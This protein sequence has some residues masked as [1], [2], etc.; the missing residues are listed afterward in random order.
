M[1]GVVAYE[2]NIRSFPLDACA[3]LQV[4]ISYLLAVSLLCVECFNAYLY[5]V[6]TSN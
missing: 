3:A 1:R 2:V 4:T 5:T 6:Q